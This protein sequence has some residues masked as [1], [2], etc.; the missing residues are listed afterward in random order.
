MEQAFRQ[1]F[2]VSKADGQPFYISELDPETESTMTQLFKVS[3]AI[4]YSI[5][6]GEALHVTRADTPTMADLT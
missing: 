6:D 3:A 5:G 1:V 4:V 2:Q